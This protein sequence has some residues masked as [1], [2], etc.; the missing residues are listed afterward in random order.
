MFKD[1]K[2]DEYMYPIL[3][4]NNYYVS[5]SGRIGKFHKISG[6][7]DK[8][9]VFEPI[10]TYLRDGTVYVHLYAP[11]KDAQLPV[12]KLSANSIYG[13][14]PFKVIYRDGNPQNLLKDNLQLKISHFEF[15]ENMQYEDEVI[16]GTT[17]IIY[18]GKGMK[19]YDLFRPVPEDYLL[20]NRRYWVSRSG[21]VFDVFTR[22]FISRSNDDNGYY[23][24]MLMHAGV[25]ENGKYKS[26]FQRVM[27]VHRLVYWVWG[28]P[29]PKGW[30]ID[31]VDGHKYNN[32]ISN[33]ECVT[34]E[35][36]LR[37]MILRNRDDELIIRSRWN[38]EQ[39]E[40]VCKMLQ[41]GNTYAQI[42]EALGFDASDSHSKDY[43][44]VSN[45]CKAIIDK[46]TFKAISKDYDI[47]PTSVDNY[48]QS[49]YKTPEKFDREVIKK[50]CEE[51]VSG[52]GPTEVSKMYPEIPLGTIYNIKIGRQYRDLAE[53]VPGMKDVIESRMR[54]LSET[55]EPSEKHRWTSTELH[56]ICQMLQDGK[57]NQDISEEFGYGRDPEKKDQVMLKNII[58]AL[59]TGRQHKDIASQYDIPQDRRKLGL[60]FPNSG[61]FVKG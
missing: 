29:I 15:V 47:K 30:T 45:L 5:R 44:A 19:T 35:E 48:H 33:L 1:I 9:Q 60:G 61:Q 49:G 3:G 41:D 26:E 28:G 54:V 52:K 42:C 46:R 21:A 36:N 2:Y 34:L 50:I 14:T 58:N 12:A 27:K 31:H 55:T 40:V 22:S 16:P 43:I 57:S 38:D 59:S 18:G 53:T 39:A 24:I 51:L 23:K 56:K 17:L 6:N 13:E 8:Y 25:M 7:Q 4:W 32:H 37:R 11:G 10:T 20:N